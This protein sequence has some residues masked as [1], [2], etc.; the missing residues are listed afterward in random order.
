MRHAKEAAEAA[1]RA[2]GE[3]LANMSHEIRT[4]MNGI[5][6]MTELAMGTDL[7]PV[8]RE[9]L[10]LV[11]VSADALLSV[12]NDILDFSKIEAGK[13]DLDPVPFDLPSF[14]GQT[15]RTLAHRAQGKGLE[16]ACRVAPGVP[17]WVLGDPQRL[18]QVVVNLV[19][20]AIKFTNEGEVVVAVEPDADEPGRLRF[21]IADTGIGIPPDKLAKV[22]EPFEQADGSTTREY[23]GTGL[24]LTISTKLV[25]LMRG[26]ISVDSRLGQGS[27][28][29][30]DARLEPVEPP[31]PRHPRV[32]GLESRPVLV[33]DDNATSRAILGEVLEG[34]GARPTLAD[35]PDSAW[36]A[37]EEASTRGEPFALALIDGV[38]PGEDGIDL[39][40]RIR[41]RADGRSMGLVIL[42]S[43]GR[44]EDPDR[45]RD[46]G[47]LACPIKPVCPADLLVAIQA[48]GTSPPGDEAPP[49][50]PAEA[51]ETDP[52]GRALRIL[53]VED[54]IINQKVAGRMLERL[55]HSVAVASNGLEALNHL[56]AANFDVVLM[57]VQMPVMDGFQAVAAIRGSEGGASNR[58]PII[59]LTA[60]AMKEDRDRCLAAGFDAYLSKPIRVEDLRA[61]LDGLFPVPTGRLKASDHK[62]SFTS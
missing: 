60:H 54:Q 53:L 23:G 24:G 48:E 35:G 14:L 31:G 20:N 32:T 28:F 3:F 62:V 13:I 46:L 36:T 38:M 17:A 55:G 49:T 51:P 21:S 33:V 37:I 5:V 42:A 6:G 44:P 27:T 9:Y 16:L 22:F 43:T 57:D 8:Q 59:A 41:A 15:L 58:Q 29:R 39:A 30:F 12:I 34:W 40:A 61:I 19:G 47:I 52:G 18:R 4:P 45:C 2:K 25:E 7:T 1:S 26:R 56:S 50:P 10:G 11:R